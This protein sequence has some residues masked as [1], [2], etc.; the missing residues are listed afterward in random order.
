MSV[1]NCG[2]TIVITHGVIYGTMLKKDPVQI[3]YHFTKLGIKSILIVGKSL[4]NIPGVKVVE[5]GRLGIKYR[6]LVASIVSATC[7]A[8]KFVSLLKEVRPIIVITYYFPNLIPILWFLS[9]IYRYFLIVKMDWDGIVRFKGVRKWAFILRLMISSK[10]CNF[11]IV[12]SYEALRN[13]VIH[14]PT[15]YSNLRVV[16]NAWSD[17]ILKGGLSH[18]RD[19]VVLTVSR[20]VPEK[21]IDVLVRAFAKVAD[22]HSDWSLRIIGPLIDVEYFNRLKNLI[23]SLN[24]EGRIH[25][26]GALAGDA[27]INEYRRASI[28]VLPSYMESSAIVRAEALAFGLPVITTRTGGSEVVR[29]CGIIVEPGDADSLAKALDHLMGSEDVRRELGAR[30]YNRARLLT[31]E[32]MCKRIVSL[33]SELRRTMK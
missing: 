6:G 17:E 20:V 8:V 2:V 13:A 9:R 24:L 14:V 16:Y 30:A 31:Y 7:Y 23:K 5:V 12:E 18:E 10:L 27:L 21:G 19:K 1:R 11:M 28:F 29:G 32:S 3:P 4:V 25:I 33:V 15:L 26:L 22:K